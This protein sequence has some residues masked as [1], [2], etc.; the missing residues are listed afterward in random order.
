MS[1]DLRSV[2]ERARRAAPAPGFGIGDLERRRAR[3]DRGRRTSAIVVGLAVA[4]A[5]IGGA[6]AV[7]REPGERVAGGA[8]GEA[9]P[10]L[11]ASTALPPATEQLLVTGPG[12]YH[13]RAILYVAGGAE[14]G[15]EDEPSG[16]EPAT[17]LDATYWWSP[18]DDSGRIVADAADGYGI[19]TGRFGSGEFP[20]HND[21]DVA[22][23]PLGTADLTRFLL[24]RSAED[25]ASP[26]PMVSP[27]PDGGPNDGQL[28]RAITDLLVDPHTTPVVRAA[29]LDVAASLEGSEVLVDRSD[30]AGRPAHVIEFENWGGTEIDRLYVDPSKHDLL[31]WTTIPLDDEDAFRIFLVQQTGVV[32]T[33]EMAPD[34]TQGVWPPTLLSVGDLTR[35]FAENA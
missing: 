16:A 13:Y 24:E 22:S 1:E 27:P 28:W 17:Q 21:I 6:F 14:P 2:L 32:D 26:A 19:T 18:G 31:A 11:P 34:R 8:D 23:F 10:T 29:L 9:T 4:V 5:G 3:R 33:I 15:V 20:N 7:L 12:Q 25:G 35:E 30:P